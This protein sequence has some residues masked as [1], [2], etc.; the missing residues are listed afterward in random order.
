MASG[1][2]K[3]TP[4][5]SRTDDEE[6]DVGAGV[7]EATTEELEVGSGVLLDWIADEEL[8]VG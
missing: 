5:N 3:E 4:A 7:D 6:V 1:V 8:E 2:L